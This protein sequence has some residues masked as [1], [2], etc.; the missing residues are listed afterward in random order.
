MEEISE[1]DRENLCNHFLFQLEEADELIC[2]L[3]DYIRV[4]MHK[5]S[6]KITWKDAVTGAMLVTDLKALKAKYSK[7]ETEK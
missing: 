4:N 6:E 2:D 7:K 1:E 5:N 3:Q